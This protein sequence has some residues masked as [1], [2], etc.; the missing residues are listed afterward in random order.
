MS[1]PRY[2]S[3][4]FSPFD[5]VDLAKKTEDIVCRDEGSSQSRKYTEF[6]VA[7]VYRGIVTA[8]C[9]GCNLRCF[10]CWSPISRDFPEKYGRY[11]LPDGVSDAYGRLG[12]GYG[13]EKARISCGE[14]TIGRR[15]LLEVLKRV[16]VLDQ[17]KLFILE[18]NG[19]LFGA[20]KSYVKEVAKFEKVYVRVSVK[21]GTPE[22]FEWKTGAQRRFFELQFRAIEHLLDEGVRFHVAAMTDPRIMTSDERRQLLRRLA[23][24]DLWLA[25]NLE[26][27]DVDPYEATLFRLKKAGVELKW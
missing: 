10:F 6:Y 20:D 7:G 13:V 4:Y 11:C 22:R 12:S 15:H 24:I 19:I 5:P 9:V 23:E 27:E 3:K 2:T 26:E 21:A 16:E 14:P 1:Y 18:T 17:V 8:C 25:K